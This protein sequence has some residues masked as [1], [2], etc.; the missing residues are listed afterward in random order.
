MRDG[1]QKH[2]MKNP[3][4]YFESQR[5]FSR[6]LQKAERKQEWNNVFTTAVWKNEKR[7]KGRSPASPTY[8]HIY[9]YLEELWKTSTWSHSKAKSLLQL[10]ILKAN[11]LLH[12][13]SQYSGVECTYVPYVRYPM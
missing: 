8:V 1:R 12:T 5:S 9:S 7:T 10:Y 6:S 2:R 3:I 4:R 11:V 13:A